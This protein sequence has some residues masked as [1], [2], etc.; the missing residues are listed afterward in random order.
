MSGADARLRIL[1]VCG[2][3]F[4]SPGEKQFL[5]F[6]QG[7]V[8]R[9]HSVM[10]SLNG[11]PATAAAE[12]ASGIA[13]LEIRAHRFRGRGLS[14]EDTA[15]AVSFRPDII[16]GLNARVPVVAACR[17]YARATGAPVAIHFED[18]EWGYS[19]GV[20]GSSRLRLLAQA[21]RRAASHFR[22][23][24]W[25]YSTRS[26]LRWAGRQSAFDAL[27]PALAREVKR[28]LGREC[29]VVLPV[30]PMPDRSAADPGPGIPERLRRGG[31]CTFTGAL[32]PQTLNDVT[33]ALRSIAQVQQR[34]IDVTFVHVGQVLDRLDP[35]AIAR[36]AGLAEGSWGFLGYRPFHEIATI[37]EQSDVLLSPGGPTEI[38]RLR[39][40]SKVQSYLASGTPT[41]TFAVGL[42][43]MLE[44][45]VEAMLTHT[46]E[47]DELA[48]ILAEILTDA[49]LRARLSEGGRAAAAR[50]FDP[51]ANVSAMESH[52]RATLA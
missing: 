21:G 43:E 42:G 36:D 5:G 38:N 2:S 49:E 4:S 16:H 1:Y 13:G 47:P 23:A 35:D 34:G 12:G 30:L 15:A 25:F 41:V 39:L 18:D 37:L 45:R 9:G 20:P 3:D 10:M 24:S 29:T 14:R 52:Y 6:A 22:P 8:R 32:H 7:L 44:D 31:A 50:L 27:T 46:D 11:N 19:R 51:E 48:A 33:I 17:A 40:P 26:S 28:R